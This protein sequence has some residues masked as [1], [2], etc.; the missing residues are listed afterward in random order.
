MATNNDV[1][2]LFRE[3]VDLSPAEREKYFISRGVPANLRARSRIAAHF[4]S[5]DGSSVTELL[6]G[7]AE[8]LLDSGAGCAG[9]RPL[10]TFR[11]VRLLGRGGSGVVFAADRIDGAIE[12]RVAVKLLRYGADS[13]LSGNDFSASGRF[14]RH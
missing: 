1:A 14:S 11:L 2:D 12:Q 6:A 4:D 5:D 9:R 13:L 8:D 7:V 3:V 10:R